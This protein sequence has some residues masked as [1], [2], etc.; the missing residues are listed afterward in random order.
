M[1]KVTKEKYK[2]S[3]Y[4]QP[5]WDMNTKGGSTKWTSTPHRRKMAVQVN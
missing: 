1:V 5:S 3:M 4:D 2:P